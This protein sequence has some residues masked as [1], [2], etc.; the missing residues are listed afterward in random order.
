MTI[1]WKKFDNQFI[2]KFHGEVYTHRKLYEGLHHEIFERAKR[3]VERGEIVD[4]LLYGSTEAKKSK[5]PY[6]VANISK[7][8]PEVTAT[9]VARSI[10][11]IT[12]SIQDPKTVDEVASQDNVEESTDDLIDGTDDQTTN[13]V[14]EN[15]QEEMIQQIITNSNLQYE[16][17]GNLVQHQVD[18]G[19]VAVPFR[20]DD[21]IRIDFKGRDVYYPHEDGKGVDLAY[22]RKFDDED[23]LHVYR[24]RVEKGNLITS[25]MIFKM[26]TTYDLSD[27]LPDEV[28]K[29]L[30]GINELIKTYNGRSTPFVQY[31]ANEKTFMNPLGA[32][33]LRGQQGK[34]DE[35]NW[36]LTRSAR[37]FEKNGKPKIVIPI[38]VFE[39]LKNE[40]L[41]KYGEGNEHLID[42]ENLEITTYG[43]NGEILQMV[44]ID[45]SKIGDIPW[46]KDLIKIMLMETQTSEKAVDFYLDGGTS[47][48]QSG[49]A[50][51]YDLF[52]SLLKAERIQAEYIHFLKQALESSLWL[53]NFT[54]PKVIIE[55]PSI[56]VKGMLPISRKELIEENALAFK[57]KVQSREKSVRNIN[58]TASDE[59]IE[60]EIAAIE[61]D[62]SSD[63]PLSLVNG[64]M[65][66]AN[67][68]DNRP[69]DQTVKGVN[70]N[71]G[72]TTAQD[73]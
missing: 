69:A 8:I 51:F 22:K 4:H 72:G 1:N 40:A 7:I 30:L 56:G 58:P 11:E 31:M 26:S 33:V 64:R 42:A 19:L 48:A 3:L 68:L 15:L 65:T 47:G 46:V 25:H 29:K 73:T 35:I 13:G 24:E 10:G 6:I 39:E 18:G 2:S 63:D 9:L 36:T 41:E 62:N 71:D 21:G 38:S 27:R 53:A 52:L 67:Q 23:H 16:H 34:Q 17:W 28:V 32:S 61:E 54:D 60:T 12:S 37:V 45:V 55:E 43:E 5:T 59:E 20:D 14:I 49:V 66:L 50:K 70:A 44:Q 57:E